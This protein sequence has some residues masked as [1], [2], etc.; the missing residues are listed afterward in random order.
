MSGIQAFG[1]SLPPR[2]RKLAASQTDRDLAGSGRQKPLRFPVNRGTL[3][4]DVRGEAASAS[5]LSLL[6]FFIA[7]PLVCAARFVVCVEGGYRTHEYSARRPRHEQCSTCIGAP[8]FENALLSAPRVHSCF[9][10]DG[11]V[12]QKPPRLRMFRPDARR[13]VLHC[14]HPLIPG[15]PLQVNTIY[16]RLAAVSCGAPVSQTS[17]AGGHFCRNSNEQVVR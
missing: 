17:P 7:F 1:F 6:F 9:D 5:S 14:A 3:P 10:A 12:S 8:E 15:T 16:R 2:T 4:V 11:I 13:C